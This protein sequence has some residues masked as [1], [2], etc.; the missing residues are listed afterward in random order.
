MDLQSVLSYLFG[1]GS[2]EPP[3]YFPSS[4]PATYPTSEDVDFARKQDYSY[5]QP[6]AHEVNNQSARFLVGDPNEEDLKTDLVGGK[7][8]EQ[9]QKGTPRLNISDLYGKAAL[10][11]EHSALAKLGFDPNRAAMD[12]LHDPHRMNVIGYYDPF[13]DKIYSN[14]EMPYNLIH[15][16]IHRGVDKL[17]ESPYWEKDFGRLEHEDIVRYLMKNKM[18][19][20]EA[21]WKGKPGYDQQIAHA[22]WNFDKGLYAERNKKL[23]EAMEKA[24]S[25]YIA[26]KHPGGPR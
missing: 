6:W 24:A 5:G 8:L 3:K 18:G 11:A 9:W 16:S 2:P 1:G 4:R 20:P 21:I 23:L 10:A 19:D 26:A 25:Q 12:T 17:R 13:K 15:E 22:E 7:R 14:A